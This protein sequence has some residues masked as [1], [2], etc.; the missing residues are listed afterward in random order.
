MALAVACICLQPAWAGK[1]GHHAARK[2]KPAAASKQETPAVEQAD[3]LNSGPFDPEHPPA[4]LRVLVAQGA[5]T[6]F[7]Q[8]GKPHGVEYAMLLELEKF[9]NQQKAKAAPKVKL[10]FIPVEAGELI[11]LLKRGDADMA[12]GLIPIS[13]AAKGLVD[14]SQPYLQDRWCAMRS[15]GND[16]ED[17]LDGLLVPPGSFGKHLLADSGKTP[18]DAPY[19]TS[20]EKLLLALNQ[21]ADAKPTLASRYIADL[22]SK[23]LPKVQTGSCL[24]QNVDVAWAITQGQPALRD[25]INR[26]LDKQG[27]KLASTASQLT[28]RYLSTDGSVNAV[29]QIDPL[30]KLA[31]F[32]PVFQLVAKANNLDW[33][34]LAAIGQRET[35]LNPIVRKNGGPTGVMQVNPQTARKM[36]VTDPHGNEG[37]ITAAARYLAHLRDLFDKSGID[38][39]DQLYFM[40]AAYNA[41]EGR[42]QQ[43]RKEAARQGLDPNRW[44]GNVEQVARRSV[45]PHLLD[46]VNSVSRFYIAYQKKAG[47]ASAAAGK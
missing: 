6:Y 22:W 37:N 7:M 20:S 38:D 39:D 45:G 33:L 13:D 44:Q 10:E 2:S 29:V 8:D 15:K 47:K 14:F 41:G 9:L 18:V 40:L 34:L 35:K 42:V 21:D 12:A 46:Y 17:S 1:A 36:G 19:G 4:R 30:D 16:G 31:F 32:A 28:Q 43:L 25:A 26:F 5:S 24:E 23:R 11:P 3:D 27:G